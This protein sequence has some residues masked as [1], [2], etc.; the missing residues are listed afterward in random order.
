MRTLPLRGE[1]ALGDCRRETYQR[2]RRCGCPDTISAVLPG[3]SPGRVRASHPFVSRVGPAAELCALR[4]NF[5][6]QAYT[7]NPVGRRRDRAP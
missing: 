3:E 6:G 1:Y 2:G 7:E 5:A 4:T